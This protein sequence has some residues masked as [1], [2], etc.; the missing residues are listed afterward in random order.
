MA[1]YDEKPKSNVTKYT[2]NLRIV[3]AKYNS[4][5]VTIPKEIVERIGLMKG[6]RMEFKV[7]SKKDNKVDIDIQFIRQ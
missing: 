6:D 4:L 2:S 7:V 5:G 3:N 1:S